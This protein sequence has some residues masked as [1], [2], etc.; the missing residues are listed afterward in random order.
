MILAQDIA[1]AA[2]IGG[3]RT[4]L[5]NDMHMQAKNLSTMVDCA[6]PHGTLLGKLVSCALVLEAERIQRGARLRQLAVH[7]KRGQID[8]ALA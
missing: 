8:N 5:C 3:L 4:V 7:V 2:Q 6:D 1:K